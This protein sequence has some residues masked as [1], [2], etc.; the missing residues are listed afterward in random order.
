[1]TPSPAHQSTSAPSAHHLN[2][3]RQM[4]AWCRAH[5][6]DGYAHTME[7]CRRLRQEVAITDPE[8]RTNLLL[9]LDVGYHASGWWRNADYD[10]CWHLSLSWPTPGALQPSYEPIPRDEINWW[11]TL[12]FGEYTRWLWHEPGGVAHDRRS[13][14]EALPYTNIEHLRLFVDRESMQPLLPRGEVYDLTRWTD[15][16]PA[17]VDR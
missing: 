8:M 4:R 6:W 11:A 7:R 16:T 1:M 14:Q 9:T 13:H 12:F 17:K 5:P 2:L 3:A 10:C 15:H